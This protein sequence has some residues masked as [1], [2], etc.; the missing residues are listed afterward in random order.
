MQLICA[1]TSRS[2]FP[3]GSF[4]PWAVLETTLDEAEAV[5]VK[6]ELCASRATIDLDR[7]LA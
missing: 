2:R 3:L 7:S 4:L 1:E 6:P 5:T